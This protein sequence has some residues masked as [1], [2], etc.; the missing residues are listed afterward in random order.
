MR[1]IQYFVEFYCIVG[2][3]RKQKHNRKTQQWHS[4]SNQF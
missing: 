3:F 1:I 4:P 2:I